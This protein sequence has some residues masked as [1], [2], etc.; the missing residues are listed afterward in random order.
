M[1]RFPMHIDGKEH[2]P[3]SGEW[4]ETEDPFRGRPWAEVARGGSPDVEAAVSAAHR[5]LT[6]G[7]WATLTHSAR[8]HVLNQ[9]AD[10]IAANAGRLVEQHGGVSKQEELNRLL[11]LAEDGDRS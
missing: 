2:P 4:F 8:G 3:V 5:A 1:Q 10:G 6:G 11:L 7:A 9:V